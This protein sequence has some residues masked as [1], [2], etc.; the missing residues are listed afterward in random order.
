MTKK[1]VFFGHRWADLPP[2]EKNL[3]KNVVERLITEENGYDV[4]V[5]VEY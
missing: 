2:K 1:C 3:L 5:H 4:I